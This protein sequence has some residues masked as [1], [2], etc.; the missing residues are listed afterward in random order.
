MT[1]FLALCICHTVGDFYLQSKTVA[2]KKEKLNRYMLFHAVVYTIP[3]VFLF[4][5]IRWNW[6]IL[7]VLG[8]HL[9][10]DILSVY[11]KRTY[12][13]YEIPIFAADQLCHLTVLWFV[14]ENVASD[15]GLEKEVL[16]VTLAVLVLF[17]PLSILISLVFQAVFQDGQK[18]NMRTV[19]TGKYIGYA[20]RT[21]VFLLCCY[22]AISTIGFI[23]AAKTLVRYKD[24]NEDKNHFQEKYLIGTLLSTIGALLAYG[25]VKYI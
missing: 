13:Q 22:G 23:I 16:A 2:E 3:F 14:A 10:I 15:M 12:S 18:E 6:S 7:L 4:L 1:E 17:K 19:R 9:V 21:V 8:S 24:I 25:F 11:G 20:E 5:L